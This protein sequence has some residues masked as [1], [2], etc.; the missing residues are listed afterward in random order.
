MT[1]EQRTADGLTHP[2]W[3]CYFGHV[4]RSANVED[5]CRV[6]LLLEKFVPTMN[7]DLRL[8]DREPP[9]D[10]GEGPCSLHLGPHTVWRSAQNRVTWSRIVSTATLRQD[11]RHWWMMMAIF[12]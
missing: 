7:G 1:D 3:L 8:V 6:S 4:A 10:C 5:H 11:R 12:N 2:V 9:E